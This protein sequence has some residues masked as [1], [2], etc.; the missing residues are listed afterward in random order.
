MRSI[1]FAAGLALAGLAYAGA[2]RVMPALAQ[3]VDPFLVVV[4]LNALGGSSLAG[5]AG[6]L[7]TRLAQDALT[8]GLSVST[9][10]PTP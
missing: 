10:S 1:R 8:G 4:V 3:A 9:A 7:A 6:G 2:V 5:L